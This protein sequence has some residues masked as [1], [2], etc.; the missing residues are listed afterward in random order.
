MRGTQWRP[1]ARAGYCRTAAHGLAD[2]ASSSSTGTRPAPRLRSRCPSRIPAT[3]GGPSVHPD[4]RALRNSTGRGAGQGGRGGEY[5]RHLLIREIKR[6]ILDGHL[7]Q[8]AL[9]G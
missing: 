3:R 4:R 1:V 7:P 8:D 5:G 6:A 9:R 2:D